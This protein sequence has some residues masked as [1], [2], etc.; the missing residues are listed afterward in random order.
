MG[1]HTEFADV[2]VA[3]NRSCRGLCKLLMRGTNSQL[4][5]HLS[6]AS[7]PAASE[8]SPPLNTHPPP[9]C[10]PKPASQMHRPAQTSVATPRTSPTT[11]ANPS[12][13]KTAA[14]R[15]TAAPAP[16]RPE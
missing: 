2:A 7:S 10:S 1:Q 14:S 3:G 12:F 13:T 8:Y 9:W 16:T 11:T 6:D 5:R 15:P 4:D